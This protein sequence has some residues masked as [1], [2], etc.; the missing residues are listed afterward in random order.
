MSGKR[1]WTRRQFVG[2][3]TLAVGAA[4]FVPLVSPDV[5]TDGRQVS[6]RAERGEGDTWGRLLFDL[7][8]GED[9]PERLHVEIETPGGRTNRV[10]LPVAPKGRVLGLPY[11]PTS[12]GS[13]LWWEAEWADG[14][15]ACG[16]LVLE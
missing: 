4:A 1:G 16:H 10:T 5:R 12:T 6:A 3:T 8:Q 13:V 7:G 11:H 14:W 9:A 2:T 15:T